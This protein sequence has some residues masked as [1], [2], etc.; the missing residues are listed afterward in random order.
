MD[1]AA[2]NDFSSADVREFWDG[3]ADIYD[4]ANDQVRDAHD[5]RYRESFTYFPAAAPATIL[6]IWSRTGEAVEFLR[7]Q[8]LA[9]T[10]IN[11]EVSLPLIN[12]ARARGRHGRYAQT[13]LTDL[14]VRSRSVDL[15][16][17]LETLEH[18]P[19][20]V[21]FIGEIHRV[22]KPQGALILSCP[23][24]F[25]EAVLR[26][27]ETFAFNHGEGPHRFLSSRIVKRLLRQGGFELLD[28]RGTLFLPF[29]NRALQWI[30]RHVEQPLNRLGLSDLGIRQ[31]FHAR[32]A[33]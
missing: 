20:P 25:A 11:L 31:F 28:H 6:N 4:R 15:V 1:I 23:P 24:A 14:P 30:D 32:P 21:R 27:Y 5:Q 19:D 16:L 29:K 18:C 8:R 22:L 9:S 10:V 33:G 12:I 26:V 13:D 7:A 3:V 17:S 2:R